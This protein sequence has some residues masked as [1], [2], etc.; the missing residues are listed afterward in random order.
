[1]TI[2][3]IVEPL[4]LPD[5]K[6]LAE[7]TYGFMIKGAVD[8]VGERMA[9]GGDYHIESCEERT[10]S[11]STH[12]DVWGFNIIFSDDGYV[13]EYDSLINIKPVKSN[14]SRLVEDEDIRVNM[15]KIVTSF[16]S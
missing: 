8:I 13:L 9:I 6:T 4:P 12:E 3:I 10:R 16:I 5:I 1:M 14:R 2:R 11:G 7:E 15:Q